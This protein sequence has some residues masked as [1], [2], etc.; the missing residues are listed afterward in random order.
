MKIINVITL[1]RHYV[2]IFITIII[3]LFLG[4]KLLLG[5]SRDRSLLEAYGCYRNADKVIKI[6]DGSATYGGD[7]YPISR[8]KFFKDTMGFD[9]QFNISYLND[10]VGLMFSK[11]S[12][13]VGWT[14]FFRR[15]NGQLYVSFFSSDR[16]KEFRFFKTKCAEIPV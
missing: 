10:K 2:A 3:V 9:S 16:K 12:D 15:Y 5:P 8:I 7:K 14:N 11:S 13:P 4:F 1:Y 6:L